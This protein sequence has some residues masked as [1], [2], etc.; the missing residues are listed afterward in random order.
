MGFSTG[1]RARGASRADLRRGAWSSSKRTARGFFRP[2]APV[3]PR[4]P[5]GLSRAT[6][7]GM[8][9]LSGHCV[10]PNLRSEILLRVGKAAVLGDDCRTAWR[11]A[12][13]RRRQFPPMGRRKWPAGCN[14]IVTRTL[15][16]GL[17][18]R[19]LDDQFSTKPGCS[20]G[21][22]ATARW[23][24]GKAFIASTGQRAAQL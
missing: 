13:S 3:S 19:T 9:E 20:T 8:I 11:I 6:R 1:R 4:G 18:V 17:A 21:R 23:P 12:R 10:T 16:R 24:E 2:A 7:W 15:I 5:D 22:S 14:R